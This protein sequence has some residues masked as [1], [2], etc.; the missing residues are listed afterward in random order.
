MVDIGC[1]T[2]SQTEDRLLAEFFLEPQPASSGRVPTLSC[3]RIKEW[4]TP[5]WSWADYSLPSRNSQV[6]AKHPAKAKGEERDH[7]ER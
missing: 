3:S 6:Q 5:N 4:L 2:P 7:Q 1:K